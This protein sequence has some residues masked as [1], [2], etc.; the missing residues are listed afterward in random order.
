INQLPLGT[1]DGVYATVP[2]GKFQ[3]VRS[4]FQVEPGKITA[5]VTRGAP[6]GTITVMRGDKILINTPLVALQDVPLA[7]FFGRL[8]DALW[9]PIYALFHWSR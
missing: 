6:F 4:S 5:P 8:W 7:G 1:I 2:K 3:E 9:W